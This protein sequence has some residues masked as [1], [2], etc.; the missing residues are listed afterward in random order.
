[1]SH[2]KYKPFMAYIEPVTLI[3][4]KKFSKK[5]KMVMTEVIRQSLTARLTPGDPFTAGFNAGIDAAISAVRATKGAQMAFPSG[6]TFAELAVV[7][8][9][10][11][12]MQENSD[13]VKGTTES[14][15]GL[16]PVL[17]Q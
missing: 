17:Q 1:L 15:Q 7:E 12:Y 13:E 16:Q 10:R 4:L 8:V 5:K 2:S 6:K 14:V 11:H 9:E 3:A